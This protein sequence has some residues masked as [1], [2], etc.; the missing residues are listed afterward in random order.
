[1]LDQGGSPRGFEANFSKSVTPRKVN[2]LPS[3]FGDDSSRRTF[4]TIGEA[5]GHQFT[6]YFPPLN[7]E[8]SNSS[9]TMKLTKLFRVTLT[10]LL[11]CTLSGYGQ[12]DSKNVEQRVDTI[13]SQM[14]LAEKLSYIGGTGFFDI[15]PIP[16]PL[17]KASINPQIFQT[18]GPLGVRGI[19]RVFG[20]HPG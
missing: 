7:I 6:G 10:A 11:A 16:D 13:L 4:P 17:L 2:I 1:M 20:F 19:P 3:F 12:Q 15:K 9:E 14:S 5:S 18:D 8:P